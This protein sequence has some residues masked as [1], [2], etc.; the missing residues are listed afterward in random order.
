MEV[1]RTVGRTLSGIGNSGEWL[2]S[3]P[4][5]P[6]DDAPAMGEALYPYL[7][8]IRPPMSFLP[9]SMFG[10]GRELYVVGVGF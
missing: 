3:S 8:P 1:L 4:G 5:C 10:P 9:A 7:N 2:T 6:G